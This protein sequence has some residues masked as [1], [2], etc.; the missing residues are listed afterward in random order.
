M[1]LAALLIADQPAQA[2]CVVLLHGLARSEKSL[3]AMETALAAQGYLV[4][5][6]GCPF[7][8]ATTDVLAQGVGVRMAKCGNQT[9]H[10]VTHSMRGV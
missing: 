5:N 1:V 3:L 8:G 4:I 10:F 7:T 6:E 9:V 2:D